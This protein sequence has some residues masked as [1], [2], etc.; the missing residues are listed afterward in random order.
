MPRIAK[1]PTSDDLDLTIQQNLIKYRKLKGLTQQELAD[2][3]GL[4][5]SA[6]AGIESGK[7]KIYGET[8]ARTA[9]VLDV[10]L[11]ELAG[12]TTGASEAEAPSLRLMR[13][14]SEIDKLPESK[15]KAILKTLDDL[16]RANS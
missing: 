12:L 11:D 6:V 14:V 10:S 9:K 3:I 7:N 1:T 8:L 15:K 16:I 2:L 4:S 5:R 13:R